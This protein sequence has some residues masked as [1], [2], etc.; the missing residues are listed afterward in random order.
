[1]VCRGC[2]EPP[3]P[4]PPLV[5]TT[6]S[7]CPQPPPLP[8]VYM[9]QVKGHVL[10][11]SF[12]FDAPSLDFGTVAFDFLSTRTFKILN[13][14]EIPLHYRYGSREIGADTPTR[15]HEDHALTIVVC[16]SSILPLL[17]LSSILPVLDSPR[18]YLCL[19]LPD[20]TCV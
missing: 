2:R 6:S 1:M 19:T 20:S 11:P 10:G 4:L 15:Y 8:L 14:C 5:H 7:S 18:F 3:F 9:S 12:R 16:L 17:C 13:Q